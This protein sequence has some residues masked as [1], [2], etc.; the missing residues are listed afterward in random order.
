MRV[1]PL[2]S[3]FATLRGIGVGAQVRG[4]LVRISNCIAGRAGDAHLEYCSHT[5][6][7]CTTES[8]MLVL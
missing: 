1:A 5:I 6:R 4:A 2:G 3:V 8:G 7:S